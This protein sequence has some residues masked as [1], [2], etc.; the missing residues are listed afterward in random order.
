MLSR[1]SVPV[2][3][4]HVVCPRPSPPKH[5]RAN[6]HG[7]ACIPPPERTI[8]V[9]E[10]LGET[11]S[12]FD[13]I[14]R[15]APAQSAL[16]WMDLL[17]EL[18]E[19]FL[20]VTCAVPDEAL[21]W[22]LDRDRGSEQ[23]YDKW[24]RRH[25]WRLSAWNLTG[26]LYVLCHYWRDVILRWRS[27]VTT[28]SLG[29]CSSMDI[30][31]GSAASLNAR[32]LLSQQLRIISRDCPALRR[33]SM[34]SMDLTGEMLLPVIQQC[35][36]LRAL[37]ARDRSNDR[38]EGI[39]ASDLDYVVW[40]MAV[41]CP[42]A[43]SLYL[44][45]T[46][47]RCRWPS[48]TCLQHLTVEDIN[49]YSLASLAQNAPLLRVLRVVG[50]R[51]GCSDGCRCFSELP[52]LSPADLAMPQ[53]EA[54]DFTLHDDV[55]DFSWLPH[56]PRLVELAVLCNGSTVTVKEARRILDR[57]P[58]LRQCCLEVTD[59]L[60]IG[61]EDLLSVTELLPLTTF[62]F[63]LTASPHMDFNRLA[64]AAA[65]PELVSFK[66]DHAD[67]TDSTIE[68]LANACPRLRKL[69][70]YGSLQLTDAALH[71][72]SHGACSQ[73]LR[74]VD[75]Q[76]NSNFSRAALVDFFDTTVISDIS[77]AGSTAREVFSALDLDD[78][79]IELVQGLL[80]R[81]CMRHGEGAYV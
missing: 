18:L 79:T 69:D 22:E 45:C 44:P 5:C 24:L 50:G 31:V 34:R 76:G 65:R 27:A 36:E 58:A 25:G 28:V 43:D 56:L 21:A 4:I 70:L 72:L 1:S 10:G 6:Q 60:G 37:E 15:S 54:L 35:R 30:Q 73:S 55:P 20:S 78:A 42:L 68:H 11:R 46:V 7:S 2:D 8:F 23:D 3:L 38:H 48:M 47:F 61:F 81:N 41:G 19:P 49:M 52:G 17:T 26:R 51:N 74:L 32:L 77:I 33:L 71:A 13:A 63:D 64:L 39:D 62:D 53:L 75:L 9:R 67:L 14:A 12:V 16:N 57:C 59:D 29:T 40:A 66:I 80:E